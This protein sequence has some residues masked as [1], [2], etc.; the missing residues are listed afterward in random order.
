MTFSFTGDKAGGRPSSA[1][2]DTPETAP[3]NHRLDP[4]ARSLWRRRTDHP[5]NA[6]RP[7]ANLIAVVSAGGR[8]ENVISMP[9]PGTA[10][11]D[12][13]K[14]GTNM[15]AI[16]PGQLGQRIRRSLRKTLQSRQSHS[17]EAADAESGAY[18]EFI[19]IPQGRDRVLLIV[20]DVSTVRAAIAK[21]EDLAFSDAETGLPNREWLMAELASIVERISMREGRGA[22]ICLEIGGLE[23]TES[24]AGN[25]CSGAIMSILAAR[26]TQALRKANQPEDGDDERYSAVARID[27]NRFAVVLPDISAGDDAAGVATRLINAL[28]AP[29]TIGKQQY[30]VDVTAGIALYPQDGK[31]SEELLS[32]TII[33]LHDARNSQSAHQ[34]FHS[35]T[36]SMEPV[37]RQDLVVALESALEKGEFKLNYLPIMTGDSRNV[38][39]AEVL[40]RWPRP[41]FGNKP[42]K[43]VI[44]A[45]DFTGVMLP[46]GKWVFA[47]ACRQLAEWHANGFEELRIAVNVSP[48]EFA[49]ARLVERTELILTDTGV[50]AACIDIEIT[51]HLLFRD[52]MRGFPV[53][54]GLA[55]LGIR[56]VVDDYGTG[57]CSFDHVADSPVH[58]VKIHEKFV[59]RVDREESSRAACA[60]ITAMAHELGIKV[61]AEGVETDAQADILSEIGCDYLQGFVFCRPSSADDLAGFLLA[62]A[63]NSGAGKPS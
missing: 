2:E 63:A 20:R 55:D 39:A 51:E 12:Q 25:D 33:A 23:A 38:T 60:A 40:L 3:G 34:K 15:D 16:W 27:A 54:Q 29:V 52:A 6:D 21:L 42:I 37:E 58:G 9:P 10:L 43:E 26:L 57:I 18:F 59:A 4:D 44:R 46:I 22:V 19:C 41:L 53:C 35:G 31:R 28:E 8:V 49:R 47:S 13:I 45:A 14:P 50:D 56:V 17:N 32:N 1:T 11:P 48:Q 62:S 30:N 5:D 61:T 36:T 24:I 7:D